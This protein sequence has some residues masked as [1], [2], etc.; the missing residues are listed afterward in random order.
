MIAFAQETGYAISPILG[1]MIFFYFLFLFW[2][3]KFLS[4]NTKNIRMKTIKAI[5]KRVMIIY[6]YI[7]IYIFF[8]LAK[9]NKKKN[10]AN[11]NTEKEKKRD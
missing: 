1:P 5:V 2:L 4:P 9:Y 8:S 7:Y 6:I 10:K 11:Q 3:I